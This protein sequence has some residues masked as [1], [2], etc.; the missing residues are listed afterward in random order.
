VRPVF[1]AIALAV[2]LAGCG[3]NER[4]TDVPGF[5]AQG[6]TPAE[7]AIL[8]S[9]ATYRTTKDAALAC[10]LITPHFLSGRFGGQEDNCEQVQREAS[11]HLPD[12]ATVQSV[13]AASAKV[14]VDEPTATKSIYAMRRMGGTW[15]IDDIVEP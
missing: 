10:S 8:R 7:R 11:R 4:N 2:V 6:K 3:P 15:K 5:I 1:A 12:S 9:I 14:L 13:S